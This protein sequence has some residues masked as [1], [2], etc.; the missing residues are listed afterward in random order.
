M[1]ATWFSCSKSVCD[2]GSTTLTTSFFIVALSGSPAPPLGLI[3][4]TDFAMEYEV[5]RSGVTIKT[6]LPSAS[7]VFLIDILNLL[8]CWFSD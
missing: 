4:T 2:G 5:G 1:S 7:V 8:G 6:E 3:L